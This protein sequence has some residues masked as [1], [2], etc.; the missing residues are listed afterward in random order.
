ME[1]YC[2]SSTDQGLLLIIF[3]YYR[4][5][6]GWSWLVVF[7][8]VCLS[9]NE[10]PQNKPNTILNVHRL[11]DVADD[12]NNERGPGAVAACLTR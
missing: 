4:R 5:Q 12:Y 10:S 2:W 1:S 6:D 11:I 8:H 9:A 7:D 3:S